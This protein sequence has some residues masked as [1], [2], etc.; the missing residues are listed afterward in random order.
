[1]YAGFI[2]YAALY[3]F[4]IEESVK[5]LTQNGVFVHVSPTVKIF[6]SWACIALR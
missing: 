3:F 5:F 4:R 1:M 2:I 6:I